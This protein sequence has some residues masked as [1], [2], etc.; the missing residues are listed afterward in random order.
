VTNFALTPA[1][2]HRGDA[3]VPLLIAAKETGQ[4]IEDVV[5]DRGYSFDAEGFVEQY[6]GFLER[7][8]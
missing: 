1:G 2:Y 5:W 4:G 6:E 7:V 3:I 8:S